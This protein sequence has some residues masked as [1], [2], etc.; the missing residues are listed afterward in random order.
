MAAKK[1]DDV[2]TLAPGAPEDPEDG[3]NHS[4]VVTSDNY[5]G[6]ERGKRVSLPDNASTRILVESGHVKPA[7]Q[8]AKDASS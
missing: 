1:K 2:V 6:G 3:P 7:S 8:A 4:Y 5:T